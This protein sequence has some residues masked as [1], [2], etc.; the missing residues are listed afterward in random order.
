VLSL[1]LHNNK[2]NIKEI[3]LLGTEV[4]SL[5]LHNNKECLGCFSVT[6]FCGS[7]KCANFDDSI[8]FDEI[9]LDRYKI[10]IIKVNE[11]KKKEECNRIVKL[12]RTKI[13]KIRKV[14]DQ[15]EID[16]KMCNEI[17]REIYLLEKNKR[18][19][20]IEKQKVK[21]ESSINSEENLTK[22]NK[23]ENIEPKKPQVPEKKEETFEKEKNSSLELNVNHTNNSENEISKNENIIEDDKILSTKERNNISFTDLADKK[24]DTNFNNKLKEEAVNDS[25]NN[26]WHYWGFPF[27]K[28]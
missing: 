20:K 2:D 12:N 26:T 21:K 18:R 24:N 9:L 22:S 6:E 10:N 8:N 28:K 19:K 27:N 1:I 25:N 14:Y 7:E 15:Y 13:K 11:V 16:E 4:L 3:V 23:N 5:I 17:S